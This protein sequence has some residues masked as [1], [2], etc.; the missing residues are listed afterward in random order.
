[1]NTRFLRFLKFAYLFLDFCTINL[2][3]I[4]SYFFF[5][6]Y[7]LIGS[8]FEYAYVIVYL[9]IAWLIAILF[10][11][12]Y[13]QT[14]ISSFE[15]FTKLTLRGFVYF[16]SFV[17]LFFFF[18]KMI[19][20]SRIFIFS[21]LLII[22]LVL[23]LT[24]FLHLGINQYYKRTEGSLSKVLIIGYNSL[25]KKL[26]SNL[27]N[28][29]NVRVIGYCEDYE[30]IKELS[31]Y[32][33]LG[34]VNHALQLC[35]EHH[36]NEIYS[37]IAPE[38]NGYLYDL[39]KVADQNCIR[40]KLIPDLGFF[41]KK[42]AYITHVNEIPVIDMHNEPLQDTGNRIKK[43]LFDVV[44]SSLVIVFVLSWLMPLISLC[45]WIESRGNVLLLQQRTGR[46]NKSFTSV[47]F[48]STHKNVIAGTRYANAG[49]KRITRVGKILRRTGMNKLPQFLNV[50]KGEM[51]IIGPRPR[52]IK[53]AGE[54]PG[55]VND[56]MVRQSLKPGITGWAQVNGFR[57]ETKSL[58]S[59][60]KR[61]KHDVWYME[62][63][64]L[65]LDLRIMFSTLF[66]VLISVEHDSD[67]QQALSKGIA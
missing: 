29:I 43:R 25:S 45:I 50:L 6:Q 36:I 1:M 38:Q 4:I 30:N 21:V 17:L 61:V 65:M 33:I 34:R 14:N 46:S 31:N 44:I 5:R 11:N 57:S 9:N 58:E 12:A 51:S 26:V 28:D 60:K 2:V 19:M 39:M 40:F 23:L 32:P 67:L 56:Y 64:S 8:E 52:M 59:I 49:D 63:W 54:Y 27:S 15:V 24:R 10:T 55:H 48:R 37:T 66:N 47:N 13:S 22:A 35:K 18:S 20:L 42:Q 53:Y 62:N 41:I 7:R 3:F 16:V